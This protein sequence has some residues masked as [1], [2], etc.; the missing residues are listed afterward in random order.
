MLEDSRNCPHHEASL[1]IPLNIR[2]KPWEKKKK[3]S[4]VES[5]GSR[6]FGWKASSPPG[7]GPG[8]TGRLRCFPSSAPGLSQACGSLVVLAHA[9][10]AGGQSHTS[11]MDGCHVLP[12]PAD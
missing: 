11:L 7:A 8:L 3:K 5:P 12:R 2:E 6:Y 4:P 10:A 9:V 1:N